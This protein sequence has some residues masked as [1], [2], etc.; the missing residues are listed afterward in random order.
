MAQWGK[1]LASIHE[2]AGSALALL[3]GLRIR[4][5]HASCGIG[6]RCGLDPG[7]AVAL[8][9]ASSCSTDFSPSLG[10]SICRS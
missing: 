10:I 1:N 5:C 7:V 3:S 6:R 4:H 8:V 9:W 2:D